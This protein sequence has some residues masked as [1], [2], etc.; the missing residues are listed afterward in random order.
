MDSVIPW[1]DID[2]GKNVMVKP[3]GWLGR[4]VLGQ[5][6]FAGSTGMVLSTQTGK[7]SGEK[8]YHVRIDLDISSPD[9]C[10]FAYGYYYVGDL[11]FLS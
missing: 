2:I 5:R 4:I 9:V 8:M 7:Y 3:R 6:E 1:V 10:P 11:E